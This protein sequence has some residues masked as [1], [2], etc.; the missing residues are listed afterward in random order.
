MINNRTYG[1]DADVLAYNARIV[2]GGNQGLGPVGMRQVN[3]FVIGLK[4]MKLWDLAANIFLLSSNQNAGGGTTVYG[5]KP[6]NDGTF[7]FN[8]PNRIEWSTNGMNFYA[9]DIDGFGING[10]CYVECPPLQVYQGNVTFFAI[11]RGNTDNN[12]SRAV[13]FV[14]QGSLSDGDRIIRIWV[15]DAFNNNTEITY[16]SASDTSANA[17]VL[18]GTGFNSVSY[19]A[20]YDSTTTNGYLKVYK[21]GILVTTT[22]TAAMT[23]PPY[24]TSQIYPGPIKLK[25][26]GYVYKNDTKLHF[27][28]AFY[29]TLS[30][31]EHKDL[32]NLIKRTVGEGLAL[33]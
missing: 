21:N 5:L 10:S 7:L 30:D 22:A 11:G 20:Y 33:P 12:L 14:N 26:G 6:N 17:R 2:A 24:D 3:Q 8:S 27:F 9:P 31:A 1:I 28:G 32:N 15:N 16:G 19:T 13:Y 18:A 23:I 4:K 25:L 29:K